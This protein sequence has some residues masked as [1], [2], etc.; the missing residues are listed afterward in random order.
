MGNIISRK[1]STGNHRRAS[2]KRAIPPRAVVNP[3][4]HR[5]EKDG[6]GDH[7]GGEDAREQDRDDVKQNG[8]D[9]HEGGEGQR[10]RRTAPADHRAGNPEHDDKGVDQ[11]ELAPLGLQLKH[12]AHPAVPVVDGL[13][14][15]VNPVGDDCDPE[16]VFV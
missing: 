16:D 1:P 10:H 7:P 9:Q 5:Q 6:G 8:V 3:D 4:P 2:G 13:F 12:P 14:H 15:H 11:V